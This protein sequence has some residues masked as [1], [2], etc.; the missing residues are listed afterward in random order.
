MATPIMDPQHHPCPRHR[1][2]GSPLGTN[3]GVY[4]HV[5][6]GSGRLHQH[7]AEPRTTG[8]TNWRNESRNRHTTAINPPNY[9]APTKVSSNATV[10]RPLPSSPVANGGPLYARRNNNIHYRN[11]KLSDRRDASQLLAHRRRQI[12]LSACLQRS[13]G[14]EDP[15][16]AARDLSSSNVC[17]QA[18][19][20]AARRCICRLWLETAGVATVVGAVPC[21]ML[22]NRDGGGPYIGTYADAQPYHCHYCRRLWCATSLTGRHRMGAVGTYEPSSGSLL[23][24]GFV[25]CPVDHRI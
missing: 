1:A 16:Q 10:T 15:V 25:P 4:T 9:L 3:K 23:Y 18:S 7:R 5:A 24:L 12:R 22:S 17:N 11:K 14:R 2:L 21:M 20:P 19:P 6:N 13:G 8:A